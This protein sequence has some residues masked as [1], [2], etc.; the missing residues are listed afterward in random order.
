MKMVPPAG[1]EPA[2]YRLGGGSSTRPQATDYTRQTWNARPITAALHQAVKSLIRKDRN[3][4]FGRDFPGPTRAASAVSLGMGC[5][6]LLQAVFGHASNR[7]AAALRAHL[8]SV[9]DGN[10]VEMGIVLAIM[11]AVMVG[12]VW[13]IL[14]AGSNSKQQ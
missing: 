5:V 11:V 14:R 6:I 8:A 10:L 12:F 1:I 2:T 13:V 4:L 3:S 7:D 9:R